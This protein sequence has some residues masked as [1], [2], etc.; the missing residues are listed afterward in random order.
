[1]DH[2]LR[3]WPVGPTDPTVV[4]A[5]TRA[6]RSALDGTGPALAPYVD[7]PAARTAAASLPPRVPDGVALVVRTSGSAGRPRWVLLD[8]AALVASARATHERLGGPGRWV[9]ALPA[10]HVAG[11]QVLVRS[12]LAGTEP[13]TLD[14]PG[15][16]PAALARAVAAAGPAPAT[17]CYVSLV[18]TQLHRVVAAATTRRDSGL[19]RGLD[20][21]HRLDAVLVGGAAASPTLL[22][23][24]RGLGLPVVTTYGMTETCGGCVY[25]GLPLPGVRVELDDG[26]VRVAGP[27]LARGYLPEPGA[28][29][30]ARDG[31]PLGA[32]AGADEPFVELDGVRWLRTADL[33]RLQ[34]GR[35]QVLGRRDDVVVSGGVKV[36]PAAVEAVLAA[37]PGVAEVCV[38]GLPD[39]EWGQEVTAVVVPGPQGGPSLVRLREAVSRTLGSAAAPRRLVLVDALPHRGPGKVDRTAAS[40]IAARH[41]S[42]QH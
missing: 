4:A 10:G 17:R 33:G 13:V 25:D 38:V 16:T 2:P 39:D 9:L 19:P 23:A 42:D 3:P 7:A 22:A 37:V 21:L 41:H 1:M 34:D 20:P 12:L 29:T 36:H 15:F 28:D 5:L 32:P 27:V 26:A 31:A 8:R 11:L 6:L 18:P 30:S 24:A 40:A 35:L 14:G